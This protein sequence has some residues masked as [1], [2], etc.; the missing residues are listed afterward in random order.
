MRFRSKR[1][2][3]DTAQANNG[4]LS[5]AEAV[6]KVKGWATTKFDQSVECVLQLGINPRQA[7]QAIRG[8]LSLPHGIG[9]S[10]HPG[11]PYR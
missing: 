7:D 9:K 6:E 1:F 5:I 2:K 11:R 3:K 4:V 10:G 8:A